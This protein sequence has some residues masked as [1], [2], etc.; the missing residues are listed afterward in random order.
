V[1]EEA[2]REGE[3]KSVIFVADSSS[4]GAHG[5]KQGGRGSRMGKT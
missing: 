1:V 3:G 2:V 4:S 5:W